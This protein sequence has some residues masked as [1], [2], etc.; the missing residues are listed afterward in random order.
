[1]L[2][3]IEDSDRG[4]LF[5]MAALFF[6]GVTKQ[7][8][9]PVTILSLFPQNSDQTSPAGR[10]EKRPW[11][12][13]LPVFHKPAEVWYSGRIALVDYYIILTL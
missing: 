9:H 3:Q 13:A 7:S 1:M 12:Y 8:F 5:G 10:P 11:N 4:R 6:K 2:T